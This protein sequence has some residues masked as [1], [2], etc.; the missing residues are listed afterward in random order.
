MLAHGDGILC[1]QHC[2]NVHGI[3]VDIS[4]W[5]GQPAY[6][7]RHWCPCFREEGINKMRDCWFRERDT[8]LWPSHL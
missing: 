6:L 3:I 7:I 4:S 8:E 5:E 2:E 1:N